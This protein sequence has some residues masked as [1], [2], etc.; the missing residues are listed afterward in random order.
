VFNK[1]V[2]L[3]H[4]AFLFTTIKICNVIKTIKFL[5]ELLSVF[6]NDN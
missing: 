6:I 1:V 5:G 3:L 2:V 4:F